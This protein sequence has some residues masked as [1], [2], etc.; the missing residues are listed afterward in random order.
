MIKGLTASFGA[1]GRAARS[2]RFGMMSR[3]IRRRV[4]IATEVYLAE[5]KI[6][7][8]IQNE[9]L[10]EASANILY[11]NEN[12]VKGIQFLIDRDFRIAKDRLQRALDEVALKEQDF[13]DIIGTISKRLAVCHLNLQDTAALADS[14]MENFLVRIS[15]PEKNSYQIFTAALNM[16]IYY[17]KYDIERGYA[18][19][20]NF[21]QLMEGNT[22]PIAMEL[23]IQ[24]ILGVGPAD[25]DDTP[26]KRRV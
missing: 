20:Q 24:L 6:L 22:L 7:K 23:E 1:F 25:A 2:V 16:A 5:N 15:D 8:D 14:L 19:Y 4:L 12:Y 3:A 11:S 17:S 18:F 26:Q 21:E 13:P 9:G 10:S